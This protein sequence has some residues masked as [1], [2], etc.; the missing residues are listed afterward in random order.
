MAASGA[1]AL[2]LLTEG[3]QVDVLVTDLAM[4]GMDGIAAIRGAR[5]HRPGLPAVLLTGYAGEEAALMAGR[6]IT[7]AYSLARKPIATDDL[8]ERIEALLLARS[9]VVA[10]SAA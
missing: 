9:S 7:G 6:P 8:V 1:E 10:G 4:P 5:E 3:E 2:A